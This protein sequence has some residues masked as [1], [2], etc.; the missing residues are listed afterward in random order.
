[1]IRL[2]ILTLTFLSLTACEEIAIQTTPKRKPS[3]LE[4]QFAKSTHNKFWNALHNGRYN[5]IPAIN[6]QMMAAYLTN[7]NDPKLAAHLGFLHMWAITERQRLKDIPPTITNEIILARY[8]FSNAIELDP[9]DARYLGFYGDS[10]LGVGKIFDDKREQV[11]GYFTLKHAIHRWPEFNY[12]TAGYPMTVLDAKSKPFKQA[13]A[14]Q[15]AT[16]DVCAGEKVNRMN[17][18]YHPYM[19][20][21]T[22]SGPQRAC[23][24]S[25]IAP[26]NFEGFFMNMG[27]MLVKSGD[28]QTAIKIYE[29]AKL[30]VDYKHWP[31]HKML[32]KRVE[33]AKQNVANFQKNYI[34]PDK[35]IMFNSGYGCMACHQRSNSV[36]K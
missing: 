6:Y 21:Q 33:N 1:M 24:N 16:L 7:P 4:S 11:R 17:P 26:Y 9:S 29:N 12:F 27:D 22:L 36:K 14:W 20:R 15:W 23:W 19:N 10:Q 30:D 2:L 31:F 5:Q 13:L 25:W 3:L 32:E 28:W 18:N 35:T 8:Y 34:S